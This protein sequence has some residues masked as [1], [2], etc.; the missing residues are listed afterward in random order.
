MI[1]SSLHPW[2]S[3][4]VRAR[5]V[6]A[7][8]CNGIAVEAVE[9]F[10]EGS[11]RFDLTRGNY[12]IGIVLEQG[13][14]RCE[15][16]T[17]VRA[18]GEYKHRG[19]PF[20]SL[21]T[22]GLELWACSEDI[23]YA[24]SLSLEFDES[25]LAARLGDTF[26]VR[27]AVAPRLNFAHTALA[28]VAE[29]LAREC[30]T[31]GPFGELYSESLVDAMLVEIARLQW[32]T[33][34]GQ[35]KLRLKPWQLRRAIEIMEA[36]MDGRARLSELARATSLSPAH[37]SRAFKASTGMP[38]YRWHLHSRITRVRQ[39]LLDEQLSIVEIA[40]AT[41]FADQAHLTRVF[42]RLTGMTPASWQRERRR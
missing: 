4:G 13:G 24:R 14:G 18:A 20:A 15:T 39:L 6:H 34:R 19:K 35:Q 40:A 23:R 10:C 11:S 38:P 31:P 1:V 22:P 41:G 26:D 16:R 36:Q 33:D 25:T 2:Q 12:R 3:V 7:G 32:N 28:T 30:R 29:L 42:H 17:S 5:T 9:W 8:H 27:R 21:S 37:F